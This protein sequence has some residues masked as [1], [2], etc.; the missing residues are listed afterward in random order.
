MRS[1][2]VNGC[3]ADIQVPA[4]DSVE[5]RVVP[6]YGWAGAEAIYGSDF[7]KES[8]ARSWKKDTYTITIDDYNNGT[9]GPLTIEAVEGRTVETI[10]GI[11]LGHDTF[12][13]LVQILSQHGI[14][15]R[16]RLH[17]ADGMWLLSVSF[18]SACGRG[19]VSEYDWTLTGNDLVNRSIGEGSRLNSRIFLKEIASRYSLAPEAGYYDK[20]GGIPST[21]D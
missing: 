21:H 13:S 3:D 5:P 19:F 14:V 2:H 18:Q 6:G 12:G 11:S 15:F 1:V 8:L 7:R 16:E 20:L 4:G 9:T 17:D 10:D